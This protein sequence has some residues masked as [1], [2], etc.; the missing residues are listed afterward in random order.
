[1][2]KRIIFVLII[3]TNPIWAQNTRHSEDFLHSDW[4]N[5]K[6]P[7]DQS[8][9]LYSNDNWIKNNPIPKDFPQWSIFRKLGK[10]NLLRLKHLLVSLP[11]HQDA[12]AKKINQ[13]LY[14]IYQ[15]GLD[16]KTIEKTK[17]I[18]LLPLIQQIKTIDS[19][20]DLAQT[21]GLLHQIDVPVFF[22][23]SS[24]FDYHR[25]HFKIAN[26]A[27]NGL[28]LPAKSYYFRNGKNAKAIQSSYLLYLK[29]LF[30]NIN[31]TPEEATKKAEDVWFFEHGLA[32]FF[33]EKAFFRNP[34]QIDNR[35][36]SLS[37]IEHYPALHFDIYFETI[38][39]SD[40]IHINN[41]TPDYLKELNNI[42]GKTSLDT[43]KFYLLAHLLHEYA[44]Y[45]DQEYSSASCQ[46]HRAIQGNKRCSA[47]WLIVLSNI[48]KYLGFALGDLYIE[49]YHKA[50]DIKKAKKIYQQIKAEMAKTIPKST[51]L[52]EET[53]ANAL[54]KLHHS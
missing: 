12:F 54:K 47:R 52:S 45:M 30:I 44:P 48:N 8:F 25:R 43:I 27:E 23:F 9:F 36:N 10:A 14:Q 22:K 29:H 37:F 6:I 51:W 7:P 41:S 13:Q 3:F 46:F 2:F 32:Q 33:H 28:L 53:R 40:V 31:L 5:T 15:S 24:F 34:H 19:S 35:S 39:F 26:I 18:P 16:I 38:G 11:I 42:I 50:G 17:N 4:M 20:Q 1:M 21:I 49:K